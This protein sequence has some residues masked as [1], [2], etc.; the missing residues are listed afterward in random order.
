MFVSASIQLPSKRSLD[1]AST[2]LKTK[3]GLPPLEKLDLFR[4]AQD[5]GL[6]SD[7]VVNGSF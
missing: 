4:T 6:N 5:V 2:R 1:K 7:N 3:T